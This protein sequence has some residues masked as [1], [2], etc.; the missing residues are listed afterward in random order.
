MPFPDDP[1]SLIPN[2]SAIKI[3]PWAHITRNFFIAIM[4]S[5][6]KLQHFLK[7]LPL[8][9]CNSLHYT[10]VIYLGHFS[11]WRIW[12]SVLNFLICQ[13]LDFFPS[14][15]LVYRP[16]LANSHAA[17]MTLLRLCQCLKLPVPPIIWFSTFPTFD[18][19]TH[20]LQSMDSNNSLTLLDTIIH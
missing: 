16:I 8:G 13:F 14:I 12:Y 7:I 2:S 5:S 3:V 18:C 10:P 15:A 20:S 17:E 6:P 9:H 4:F 1:S 11:L 19:L